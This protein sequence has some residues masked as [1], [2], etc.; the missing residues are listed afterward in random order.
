[1]LSVLQLSVFSESVDDR[2]LARAAHT[3]MGG[4][5]LPAYLANRFHYYTFRREPFNYAFSARDT[6]YIIFIY[7][8]ILIYKKR[9][10]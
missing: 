2:L 4:P 5:E 7:L 1:M 3:Q 6:G 10:P 9:P 8:S